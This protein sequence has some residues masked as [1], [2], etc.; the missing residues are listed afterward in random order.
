MKI[1]SIAASACLLL[2][3]SLFTSFNWTYNTVFYVDELTD[4]TTN[5]VIDPKIEIGLALELNSEID[6]VENTTIYDLPIRYHLENLG[7]VDIE[8]VKLINDLAANFGIPADAIELQAGSPYIEFISEGSTLPINTNYTGA[9]PNDNLFADDGTFLKVNHSAI[10]QLNVK[11]DFRTVIGIVSNQATVIAEDI[12][13]NIDVDLSDE[14]KEVDEDKTDNL[15]A[16]GPTENDPTLIVLSNATAIALALEVSGEVQQIG[17]STAYI[18]PLT[19]RMQN[20][21]A[22]DLVSIQIKNDLAKNFN[23]PPDAITIIETPELLLL[24]NNSSLQ[25]NPNFKGIPLKNQLL[26][27]TGNFLAVGD[28]AHIG[29]EVRVD[30][31][32]N[33]GTFTNQAIVIAE[34]EIGFWDVDLSDEGSKWDENPN[35]GQFGSGEKENDPTIIFLGTDPLNQSPESR[36]NVVLFMVDDLND[37]VGTMGGH[38]DAITPNID[39]LA[40]RG[41]LFKNAQ[42]NAVFCNPSR[43]S[44]I[45]GLKPSSSGVTENG[46][47]FEDWRAIMNDPNGTAVKNY[48]PNAGGIKTMFD[49]F[50][51]N[52]YYLTTVGKIMHSSYQTSMEEWDD[53]RSITQLMFPETIANHPLNGLDDYTINNNKNNDWGVI[54][55][56]LDVVDNLPYTEDE[57]YDNRVTEHALDMIEDL[58]SDQSF[59]MNVGFIRP[60][61]P[62]Y[63]PQRYLDMYKDANGNYTISTPA[64]ILSGDQND[65]PFQTTMIH[66]NNIFAYPDRWQDLTAHYLAAVTWIDDQIGIIMDKLEAENKLD[67]TIIVF[68]SDHGFHVGEKQ[69]FKKGTLWRES[70]DV[71]FIIAAPGMNT[72][73]V[74]DSVV[75]LIDLFPTLVDLTGVEM[76]TDFP[77]DGRSLRPLLEDAN[78]RWPWFAATD[79]YDPKTDYNAKSIRTHNTSFTQYGLEN[80]SPPF[81]DSELYDLNSDEDQWYNL[82][83]GV[84]GDPELY[85]SEEQRF[86]EIVQGQLLPNV[87]PT[88]IDEVVLISQPKEQY[89]IRIT[90][91][92]PNKDYLLF[93]IK[94]MPQYGNLYESKD[95]QIL[96]DPITEKQV[97]WNKQGWSATVVYVPNDDV[98]LKNDYFVFETTDG[99]YTAA[100][101]VSISYIENIYYNITE[102]NKE[103][104]QLNLYPNPARGFT[105]LNYELK[106]DATIRLNVYTLK[107]EEIFSIF[108]GDKIKGSHYYNLNTSTWSSGL[109]LVVLEN[110]GKVIHQKLVVE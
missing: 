29:F 92:D 106:E 7:D 41:T 50:K 75:S 61:I 81:L 54:G 32:T 90:G 5:T 19:Y 95:G 83:S 79:M 98:E 24:G 34:N 66:N 72:N 3:L 39:A 8:N 80:P 21:G 60:H 23:L 33:Y 91:A 11:V 63:I 86:K 49:V 9:A 94:E 27:E 62:M 93:A 51:D 38:P 82:L 89:P 108:E 28:E 67:N 109:Y 2:L 14:G 40:A 48:G 97:L 71:P 43:V 59:L 68:A 96:G 99:V 18:F 73:S 30:F 53:S 101:T 69:F 22:T 20:M 25:I 87:A 100:G 104:I 102:D 85:E 1:T 44:I 35:D 36:P 31:G 57:A 45:T 105:Q 70:T 56:A 52:D 17:T 103:A 78:A 42:A 107:G 46:A 58:P 47:A 55:D 12:D 64:N 77:R 4:K 10:I 74:T 110:E 13:G 65:T 88:A 6:H 15:L 76:P 26:S 37:W 16:D 84:N